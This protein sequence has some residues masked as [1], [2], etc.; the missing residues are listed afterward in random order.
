M[1][2]LPVAVAMFVGG[3][4]V[5]LWSA[6]LFTDAA[7]K[8]GLAI[9]LSPFVIGMTVVAIGTS[10][11]ELVAAVLAVLRDEPGIVV[12]NVVGSNVS[13]V[14]LVLGITAVVG[15]DVRVERDLMQVDLPLFAA[16]AAF[17]TLAIWSSP[18]TRIEGVLALGAL[19]VYIHFTIA[20]R[21]V[22]VPEIVEEVTE[23]ETDLEDPTIGAATYVAFVG[24]LVLVVGSASVLVDSVVA[25]SSA[26]AVDP[27]LIAVTALSIGT[28]LPELTVSV[29]AARRGD[30]AVAVGA[31][32]GS[33]VVN[34]F[35]VMGVASLVG[36]LTIPP[37]IR[38]YGLPAMVLATV[39]YLFVTQDRE[40]TR[41]EGATLVLMYLL[42]LVNL[43]SAT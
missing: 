26:L 31:I 12:G 13:N 41:W 39:L 1:A 10:L 11:P 7:Q 2:S 21:D 15:R 20:E 30:T 16:S 23:A 17:L 5:L 14:F 22:S 38:A 35:G 8:I 42:F 29:M 9:G 4:A 25:L 3:L 36:T 40:V 6:D 28:V 27:A 43:A 33:N 37:T 19:A 18:F 34:A 24:G 32:L